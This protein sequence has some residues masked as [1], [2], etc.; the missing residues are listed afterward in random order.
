[1]FRRGGFADVGH[2]IANCI[3]NMQNFVMNNAFD[4]TFQV[5]SLAKK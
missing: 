1:V 2:N 5:S 3:T 4:V